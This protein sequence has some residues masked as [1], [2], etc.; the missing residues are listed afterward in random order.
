MHQ[1]AHKWKREWCANGSTDQSHLRMRHLLRTSHNIGQAPWACDSMEM[2]I[3]KYLYWGCGWVSGRGVFVWYVYVHYS[4]SFFS[5]YSMLPVSGLYICLADGKENQGKQPI[6]THE[7]TRNKEQWREW[8]RKRRNA[9]CQ[10]WRI[11]LQTC[12]WIP[13]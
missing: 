13:L 7:C 3:N 9:I 10:L 1:N 4:F 8:R 6:S 5:M 11:L 2:W 12:T